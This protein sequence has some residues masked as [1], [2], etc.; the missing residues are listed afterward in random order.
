MCFKYWTQVDKLSSKGKMLKNCWWYKFDKG[1]FADVSLIIKMAAQ[2][3]SEIWEKAIGDRLFPCLVGKLLRKGWENYTAEEMKLIRT[4]MWAKKMHFKKKW[5]SCLISVADTVPVSPVRMWSA[6]KCDRYHLACNCD[7]KVPKCEV[8]FLLEEQDDRKMKI[9]AIDMMWDRFTWREKH[10]VNR[11][12]N[13][14]NQRYRD[15]VAG[16]IPYVEA[17]KDDSRDIPPVNTDADFV[18]NPKSLTDTSS[19]NRRR[20][21]TMAAACDQYLISDYT[22]AAI[23][24]SCPNW[25]LHYHKGWQE[26]SYWTT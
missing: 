18:P 24:I 23:A 2:D 10:D 4:R 8:Q 1:N 7:I 3:C 17:N 6:K 25:L 20:L 12:S 16:Y 22:G 26:S 13:Q 9:A 15:L 21:L 5:R 19:Q 14:L 11:T